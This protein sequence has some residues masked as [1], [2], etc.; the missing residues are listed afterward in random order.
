MN[1]A[2]NNLEKLAYALGVQAYIYGYPVVVM[3]ETKRK[4]T[5]TRAPINQFYYSERLA[6]PEF[7]DIVAPNSNTLYFS[8]WLD[9]SQG[10]I[11]LHV[12]ENT[13]NRY[14]TVQ[15]LDAY[16]NTFQNV[17]SRSTGG[18]AGQYAIVGP[19]GQEKVLSA[20]IKAPTNSVWLI[21]RVEVDGPQD[22]PRAVAFEKQFELSAFRQATNRQKPPGSTPI[23][24]EHDAAHALAFFQTMTETIKQN[25]PPPC[26]YL[27]LDQFKPIG[28]DVQ[29]GLNR[30]VLA[31]PIMT[32]LTR[33][34]KDA[35]RIIQSLGEY[36]PRESGWVIGR[37]IGAYGDQF[38]LRAYVAYS[39]IGAN[40][41]SEELYA[42]TFVDSEG[43]QLNGENRYLL[44]FEKEQIPQVSAFWSLTMYGPDFYLVPNA[45]K[46]YTIGDLTKGLR[47]Q[48]DGSLDIYLQHTPP[49]GHES[50]WLPAPPGD[51]N[52]VIRMFQPKPRMLEKGY[53]LPPVR[54][55]GTGTRTG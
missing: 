11:V 37:D 8:A 41:P 32:G 6:T 30:K 38:L 14:Y 46:R 25:P 15:M 44:H 40:V 12:P 23:T 13:S 42:R 54:R 36:V 51:F 1:Q 7:T 24:N 31:P 2:G 17:S 50:N 9:L 47:Y 21:G 22:L 55:V 28:I 18:K 20:K 26:D 53:T 52:L 3:E 33:A 35:M 45:I 27:L 34:A 39:G 10:P 19:L 16:T 5:Q 48:A 49:Q 43:K 29:T 4:M